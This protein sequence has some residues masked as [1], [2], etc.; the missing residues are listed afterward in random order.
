MQKLEAMEQKG[1]MLNT[2]S[3]QFVNSPRKSALWRDS[4]DED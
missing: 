3:S 4:Q 2:T 1:N